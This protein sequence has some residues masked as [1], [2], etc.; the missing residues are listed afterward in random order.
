MNWDVPKTVGFCLGIGK[1]KVIFL[2]PLNANLQKKLT[3]KG[4]VR[5]DIVK[6]I[7]FFLTGIQT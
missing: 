1:N 2:N 3:P 7:L 6:V 4:G 5:D